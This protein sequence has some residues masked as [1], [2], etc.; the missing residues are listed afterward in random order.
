MESGR[1]GVGVPNSVN[2]RSNSSLLEQAA[3]R[4]TRTDSTTI[5]G[6]ILASAVIG[7]LQTNRIEHGDLRRLD[8]INHGG[9]PGIRVAAATRTVGTT[10]S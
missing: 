9:S 6:L 2:D 4:A 10:D 1:Y 8:T 3:D 5:N 7:S